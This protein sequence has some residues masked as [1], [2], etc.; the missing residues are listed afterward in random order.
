M[1]FIIG[2]Y[3]LFDIDKIKEK[4]KTYL[5][6]KN[7]ITFNY[8]KNIDHEMTNYFTALGKIILIQ[9]IEYTLIF[10]IIGHPNY[11]ILG[12]LSG[13]T[14]VIPYFGGIVTDIISLITA[15]VIS[16][17]LFILTLIINIIFPNID[18]YIISPKIYGRAIKLHPLIIIFAILTGG[19]L[20]GITGI[21]ISL[22]ITIIIIT[23]IKFYA[24]DINK[25]IDS[26]KKII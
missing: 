1:S 13:L 19:T 7:N 20:L 3:F 15:S 22:P 14:S 18:A 21:L 5:N 26:I 12:I 23:T 2:I 11:L 9:F 6:K 25:S 17:K 8:I 16:S 4:I 24:K 10:Y